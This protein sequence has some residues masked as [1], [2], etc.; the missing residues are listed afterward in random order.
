M[1]NQ[2]WGQINFSLDD[3]LLGHDPNTSKKLKD[4]LGYVPSSITKDDGNYRFNRSGGDTVV[5]T[6][7]GRQAE[8]EGVYPLDKVD[9]YK[10]HCYTLPMML[11]NAL[12]RGFLNHENTQGYSNSEILEV[13]EKYGRY[14]KDYRYV[15][16][17]ISS[18]AWFIMGFGDPRKD[19]ANGL[20]GGTLSD[21]YF[22]LLKRG[23]VQG[24]AFTA[25]SAIVEADTVETMRQLLSCI[26]EKG[27][28]PTGLDA[29]VLAIATLHKMYVDP[30]PMMEQ[31]GGEKPGTI[32]F[33]EEILSLG[34]GSYD[35]PGFYPFSQAWTKMV[36]GK[37]RGGVRAPVTRTTYEF[38]IN[39]AQ[40][41]AK[42]V[43]QGVSTTIN[44]KFKVFEVKMPDLTHMA[45]N[46]GGSRSPT[47][48]R[49]RHFAYMEFTVFGNF[50]DPK[51]YI[52]HPLEGY[53]AGERIEKDD[54]YSAYKTL[55]YDSVEDFGTNSRLE[56]YKNPQLWSAEDGGLLLL[57][58]T[59]A[60]RLVKKT[61]GS[62]TF[63]IGA[64]AKWTPD[65]HD[66]MELSDW[67]GTD[68]VLQGKLEKSG[69]NLINFAVLKSNQE[70]PAPPTP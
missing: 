2:V 33:V 60:P 62:F 65:A 3:V 23:N 14:F 55:S 46:P 19:G 43:L 57:P 4:V 54:P 29:G 48:W 10:G 28:E 51:K 58:P 50:G 66:G 16:K 8:G 38:P 45:L 30:T 1:S 63:I 53:R 7:K 11:G 6:R 17:D 39:N 56:G 32:E 47:G 69:F 64:P 61:A 49:V 20:E 18:S 68:S 37:P 9:M 24:A 59:L 31:M 13:K 21:E 70:T 35:T 42:S 34:S 25:A 5:S 36:D 40:I 27:H 15:N 67:F 52:V 44:A 41:L 22:N 26:P 12:A